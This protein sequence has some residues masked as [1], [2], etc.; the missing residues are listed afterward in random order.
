M[1]F[2]DFLREYMQDAYLKK[3]EEGHYDG[4]IWIPGEEVTVSF[5]AAITTFSDDYL[6]FGESGTYTEDDRKVFTYKKLERGQKITIANEQYTITGERDY[7]F[8]ARG[9]RMYISEK[10]G[11]SDD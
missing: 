6:Q 5:K 11:E 4:G 9:L 8:Y 1:D 10:D 7:S 3:R 2:R